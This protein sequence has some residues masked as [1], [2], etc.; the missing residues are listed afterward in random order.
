MKKV[1]GRALLVGAIVALPMGLLALSRRASQKPV[2]AL[3]RTAAGGVASADA[4]VPVLGDDGG[5]T[6]SELV[7]DARRYEV[8]IWSF[9]LERYAI[10]IEDVAMTTALDR[11]LERSGAELV[12][13]GGFFDPDGKPV[14]LAISDGAVLSRLGSNLSGGVLTLVGARAE[15]FPAEGFAM[16]DGG[17]FAIQCRP[18]LVVD[19]V[20]NVKSDDGARAERTAL[21]TRDRGRVVDVVVVRA[22]D[23]GESAGPSLFALARHLQDIGCESALNLDGG[24]STGV[25]WRDEGTVRLLAPRKPIR[26][27]VV[28]RTR[29]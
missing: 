11:V 25:A 6:R 13:N 3:P 27:A 1:V 2:A 18:R 21:C 23:D 8:D 20:A 19:R 7:E 29:R 12:V 15:L 4:R 26:H 10:G 28:F 24:P 9:G 17:T 5:A 22:S 16:P 14:G